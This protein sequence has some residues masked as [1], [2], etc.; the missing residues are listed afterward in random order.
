MASSAECSVCMEEYGK[1]DEKCPKLLPC[2]HTLCLLCLKILV[3]KMIANGIQ[4]PECRKILE[5]PIGGVEAYPTNRYVLEIL[6]MRNRATEL[7]VLNANILETYENESTDETIFCEI[8]HKP[9][10]MFCLQME[11]WHLLCPSCPVQNHPNHKL[12]SLRE[13]TQDLEALKHMNKKIKNET[14]SLA[15]YAQGI[16]K[17]IDVISEEADEAEEAIDVK[18]NEI[19]REAEQLKLQIKI[20]S[21]EQKQKLKNI[22]EGIIACCSTGEQIQEEIEMRPRKNSS[23]AIDCLIKIMH[24]FVDFTQSAEQERS[25]EVTYDSVRFHNVE[26]QSAH[27]NRLG[28]VALVTHI[29]Q[30]STTYNVYKELDKEL[31]FS[32]APTSKSPSSSEGEDGIIANEYFTDHLS[33]ESTANSSSSSEGETWNSSSSSEGEDGIIANEYLTDHLSDEPTSKSCSLS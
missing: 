32:V 3:E 12:I 20:Q 21:D 23:N 28:E 13:C 8:H 16:K 33:D 2:S 26:T 31:P 17:G 27:S 15:T 22:H 1:E 14:A 10:V 18:V 5:V 9:C 19:V 29:I 24:Q 6:G 11:C 7:E 25:K 30:Q 4:C